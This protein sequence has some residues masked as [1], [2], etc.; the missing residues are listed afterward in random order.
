LTRVLKPD[1]PASLVPLISLFNRIIQQS[2]SKFLNVSVFYT[3]AT[4]GV[5]K[6]AR[7]CDRRSGL[8]LNP[9]RPKLGQVIDSV[10]SR[11]TSIYQHSGRNAARDSQEMVSGVIVGVC[12]PVEL[13]D[14]VSDAVRCVDVSRR[15]AVGGLELY[16]E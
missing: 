6:I 3:R 9:G 16:E 10:I 13:G 8:S 7:Q 11:V 15:E 14:E 1:P 12:G 2:S 5:E 4:A